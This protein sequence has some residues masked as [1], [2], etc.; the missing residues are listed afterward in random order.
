[1]VDGDVDSSH[2]VTHTRHAERKE[3]GSMYFTHVLESLDSA[4]TT[5][6]STSSPLQPMT[7]QDNFDDGPMDNPSRPSTPRPKKSKV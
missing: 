2:A 3:D 7:F 4:P 5:S 1:M 6:Q